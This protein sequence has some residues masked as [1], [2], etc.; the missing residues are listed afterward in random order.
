MIYYPM[1]S[2]TLKQKFKPGKEELTRLGAEFNSEVIP[3]IENLHRTTYW[4]LID[5][6]QTRNLIKKVFFEAMENCYVTKNTA[7]WKSWVYR[8]WIREIL[9]YYSEKE[10]DIKTNFEFIDTTEIKLNNFENI[11]TISEF[12]VHLNIALKKLPAVLR[13]PLIMKEVLSMNYE[14]ISELIDVPEGVIA[15][16]IYRARKLLC[17]FLLGGFDYE[18]LKGKNI[19]SED[20]KPIFTLRNFALLSD[21]ELSEAEHKDLIELIKDNEL[22]ETEKRLQSKVK[23]IL[24]TLK[25]DKSEELKIK[26][27]I[28]KKAKNWFSTH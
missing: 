12:D 14:K 7:D 9:D 11:F 3:I 8:I 21:N 15:T 25:G 27:K 13:I 18:G 22:Y 1:L 24:N 16:R 19:S 26:A 20:T 4:I 5:N 23:S 28:E 17:L 2:K 6:R 10:N